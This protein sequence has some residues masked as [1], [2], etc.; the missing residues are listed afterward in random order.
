MGLD[1]IFCF[2]TIFFP[3][4]F[5]FFLSSLLS[6]FLVFIFASF[7]PLQS[8]TAIK[9]LVLNDLLVV[10]HNVD[11]LEANLIEL[12]TT[13]RPYYICAN[14]EEDLDEWMFA[15]KYVMENLK[16]AATATRKQ[17][18]SSSHATFTMAI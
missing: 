14:S 9:K 18:T 6:S 16:L 7:F 4:F 15:F 10:K 11:R 2:L 12:N 5:P 1:L 3:L 13:N 8:K 17:G